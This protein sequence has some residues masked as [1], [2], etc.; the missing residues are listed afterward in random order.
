[1]DPVVLARKPI[2]PLASHV[3]ML[4]YCEE[5]PSVY[6]KERVLPN[7]RFQLIIHLSDYPQ[8]RNG[9]IE[10]GVPLT[11]SLIVGMRSCF[12]VVHTAA[13]QSTIGA[14]FR[15]GCARAFF[16][17]RADAFYNQRV[18][19]ELLW[20][21]MAGTLRNRLREAQTPADK[22]RKLESALLQR[23]NPRLE[24]HAAVGFALEEFSRVPHVRRVLEVTREA[25]LS[26]RRFAQLFREQVGLT[27][28]L[29]C[30]LHRFQ[31]ALHQIASG[32]PVNW[33]EVALAGGYCDQAHFGHEFHEFSGISPG[34][35]LAGK[36]AFVNHVRMD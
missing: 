17:A 8:P 32:A 6:P 5:Y 2:E 28:K 27:P 15:P 29:Y 7:G 20:G 18:P 12:S 4:W 35:Y 34:T 30:R 26:R 24:L 3:E 36:P 22:F 23:M 16:D 13:L 25:G 10:E 9:A 31:V 14:V 33:A 19:L 21:S 1:M 11:S